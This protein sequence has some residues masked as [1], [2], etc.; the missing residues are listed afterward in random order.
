MPSEIVQTVRGTVVQSNLV[1]SIVLVN[2]FRKRKNSINCPILHVQVFV[3]L[4]DCQIPYSS[5]LLFFI[6]SMAGLAGPFVGTC[7]YLPYVLSKHLSADYSLQMQAQQCPIWLLLTGN[8]FFRA[9]PESLLIF[10]RHQAEFRE[11]MLELVC[12]PSNLMG[13]SHWTSKIVSPVRWWNSTHGWWTVPGFCVSVS[14][15]DKRKLSQEEADLRL[16]HSK[17]PEKLR[18]ALTMNKHVSLKS[19]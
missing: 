5:L 14:L 2:G 10:V 18:I 19:F 1:G 11:S 17:Q 4:L 9:I 6:I 3:F 8:Y 12:S 13:K 7:V 15:G 16:L